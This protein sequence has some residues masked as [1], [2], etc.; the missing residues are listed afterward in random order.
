MTDIRAQRVPG[1]DHAYG[2]HDATR[3]ENRGLKRPQTAS[4][5]GLLAVNSFLFAP[6]LEPA[7]ARRNI[8]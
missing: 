7:L 5:N 4:C 2:T 3:Q 8:R 6:M 1:Q